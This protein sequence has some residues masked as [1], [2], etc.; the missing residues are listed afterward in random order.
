MKVLILKN[1]DEVA[2]LVASELIERIQSF[3]P[4]DQKPFLVLGL[5]TG[6]TPIPVYKLLVQAYQNKEISFKNVVTFNMDEYKGLA[7][8]HNQSYHYFMQ[9]NLFGLIDIPRNQ[10]H[11]LDGMA[12]DTSAECKA[13]EEKI[14]SFGGIDIQLAGIGENGHLAFNEPGTSF[15]SLTHEQKLTENTIEVNS[16]FFEKKEDVP[17]SALTIGLKTV[18]EAKKVI[19]LATG[20]KKAEAV[21][22]SVRM[23]VT[24]NCPASILQEHENSVFVCDEGAGK[25][26]K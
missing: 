20:E 6:S 15:Q 5:P 14:A 3:K 12:K 24:E 1:A 21:Y 13:Y 8:E 16:R 17:T 26:L 11:I 18:F 19:V 23:P 9:E 22:K 7:A 25:K 10:I 4:T 2:S